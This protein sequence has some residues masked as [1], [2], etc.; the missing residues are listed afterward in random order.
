MRRINEYDNYGYFYG[1]I[2]NDPDAPKGVRTDPVASYCG[3]GSK[4]KVNRNFFVV[5]GCLEYL[6][7]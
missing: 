1:V 5:Q 3:M 7:A 2:V 6:H 4:A